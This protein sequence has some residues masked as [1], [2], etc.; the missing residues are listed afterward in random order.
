MVASPCFIS[1]NHCLYNSQRTHITLK[2]KNIERTTGTKADERNVRDSAKEKERKSMTREF[3]MQNLNNKNPNNKFYNYCVPCLDRFG[4]YVA[5]AYVITAYPWMRKLGILSVSNAT[6]YYSYAIC[7]GFCQQIWQV[8]GMKNGR[9]DG[10]L[11]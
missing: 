1:K 8:S 10:V 2:H 6:M 7:L 4:W 9:N 3:Y 11:I 5:R